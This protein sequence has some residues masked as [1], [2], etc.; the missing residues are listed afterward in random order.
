ME[1]GI[2]TVIIF[3]SLF[4]ALPIVIT[5]GTCYCKRLDHEFRMA[6]PEAFRCECQTEEDDDGDD[7]C[8]EVPGI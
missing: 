2:G 7:S 1:P 4:V 3:A 8:D 6:H 5:I